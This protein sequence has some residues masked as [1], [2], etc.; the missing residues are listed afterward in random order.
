VLCVSAA[1]RAV[2]CAQSVSYILSIDSVYSRRA[3][4]AVVLQNSSAADGCRGAFVYCYVDIFSSGR[5]V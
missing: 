1:V 4:R 3:V 5:G 2:V